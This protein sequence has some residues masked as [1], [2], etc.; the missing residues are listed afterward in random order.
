MKKFDRDF[1]HAFLAPVRVG[2]IRG[3]LLDLL[4]SLPLER[5]KEIRAEVMKIAGDLRT[6]EDRLAAPS[7][8]SQPKATKPQKGRQ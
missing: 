7:H 6:L 3:D 4:I 5:A 2:A 8:T 1:I